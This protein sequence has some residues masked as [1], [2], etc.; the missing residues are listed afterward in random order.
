M[1]EM[2]ICLGKN[3]AEAKYELQKLDTEAK[4][5]ALSAV[6]RALVEE[7]EAILRENERDI[8]AGEEKGMHP[9]L[10]DRLRLTKER[11]EGMAEGLSQVA[12]LPDPIGELMETIERRNGLHIEKR[13]CHSFQ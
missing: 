7:T 2:L 8:Q 3:A 6:A 1:N 10:V 13:R 5:K 11:I 12:E 4:N 9:G